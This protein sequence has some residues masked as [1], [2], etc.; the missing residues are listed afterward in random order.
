M[1]PF[2]S[3]QHFI[4][5]VIIL[6][7]ASLAFLLF[8]TEIGT[9]IVRDAANV[10]E[11]L[12]ATS[13]EDEPKGPPHPIYKPTPTYTPPPVTEHLPGTSKED[14]PKEPPHPI[15]KPTPTYTPS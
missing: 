7:T 15:Y 6:F 1:G 13:K 10:I 2:R 8:S 14:D 9:S 12:P 11:H 3:R 5:V 4:A